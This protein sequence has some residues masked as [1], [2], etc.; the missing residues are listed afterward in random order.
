MLGEAR[1]LFLVDFSHGDALNLRCALR[2][3]Q[4]WSTGEQRV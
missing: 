1:G 2:G 4:V 3:L